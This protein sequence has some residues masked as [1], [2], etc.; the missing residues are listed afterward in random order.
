MI[1][2]NKQKAKLCLIFVF[3]LLSFQV[4][5]NH[6]TDS[7]RSVLNIYESKIGFKSDTGYINTILHLYSALEYV[8]ADSSLLLGKYAFDLSSACNYREGRLQ[9]LSKMGGT[10]ILKYQTKEGLRLLNEALAEAEKMDDKKQLSNIFM[11]LGNGYTLERNSE[12][13]LE[14]YHESIC[15]ADQCG[16]SIFRDRTVARGMNNIANNYTSMGNLQVALEYF[17][18]AVFLGKK[19]GQVSAVS[20]ALNNIS[21]IYMMQKKYS[22]ALEKSKEALGIAETENNPLLTMP[23]YL[24]IAGLYSILKEYDMALDYL[25][26]AEAMNKNIGNDAWSNNIMSI[27]AS[28]YL[29]QQKY[30]EVLPIIS[31]I[32][33]KSKNLESGGYYGLA[34]FYKAVALSG[35]NQYPEALD[36]CNQALEEAKKGNLL[37]VEREVHE[38]MSR[39]YEVQNKGMYALEHYKL[40]KVLSD[41]LYNDELKQQS[42]AFEA[43]YEYQKKESKLKAEQALKETEFARHQARLELILVSAIIILVLVVVFLLVMTRSRHRLKQAYRKLEKANEE[44]R[45]QKEEISKQSGELRIAN[46]KLVGLVKFKQDVSGMI[47]HDL[48]NPLS[49]ILHL[50]RSVP[51]DHALELLHE[52]AQSMLGLVLNILDINKYEDSKLELRYGQYDLCSLFGDT[53]QDAELSAKFKNISFT[54]HCDETLSLFFDRDIIRRVLNNIVN[55]AVKFSP[56]GGIIGIA[57][58]RENGE[59]MVSVTNNGRAIPEGMQEAIFEPY[60]KGNSEENNSAVKSTGLGLTFCKMAVAAHGGTIGV[61]SHPGAPTCFWFTLPYPGS[62]K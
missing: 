39:I 6:K 12:K 59:V 62:R 23:S 13:A 33:E 18:K 28:V 22:E 37:S 26:K 4:W 61:T 57:A 54:T 44:I 14:M 27:E 11:L 48:K 55:N 42:L 38:L 58:V 15:Y 8:N 20:A 34:L 53:V 47:V 51:D 10:L 5:P 31:E 1:I 40:F 56:G 25:H 36:F 19:S 52:S 45:V 7:L 3:T 9:S 60:G 35:L 49:I 21:D 41:S 17:S 16:D 24:K 46:E 43:Q 50:T 29:D 2:P 32:I 30:T